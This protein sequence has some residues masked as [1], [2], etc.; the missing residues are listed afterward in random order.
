VKYVFL[1]FFFV[2]WQFVSLLVTESQFNNFDLAREWC[3]FYGAK[4]DN[5]CNTGS[6]VFNSLRLL[7]HRLT[8][9]KLLFHKHIVRRFTYIGTAFTGILGLIVLVIQR[10]KNYRVQV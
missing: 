10:E 6:F 2:L 4:D 1:L 5:T 8:L 9:K 7:C 3:K